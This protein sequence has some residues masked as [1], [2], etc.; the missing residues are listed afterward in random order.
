MA[1]IF[2]AMLIDVLQL[3]WFDVKLMILED[4]DGWETVH[5]GRH[6]KL[7]RTPSGNIGL[8]LRIVLSCFME[9]CSSFL[10]LSDVYSL[11]LAV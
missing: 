11:I 4:L 6:G 2:A 7:R 8:N 1:L 3:I 9:T 10:P 5:K